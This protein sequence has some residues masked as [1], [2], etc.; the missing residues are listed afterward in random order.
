MNE[1]A[2][3]IMAESTGTPLPTPAKNP[4]AV[5][6]GLLGGSKGGKIRAAKLSPAKRKAI[7]KKAA[8]IRWAKRATAPVSVA[9]SAPAGR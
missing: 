8:R 4:H 9:P 7:A 6:L 3:R 1:I 5:A 2:F